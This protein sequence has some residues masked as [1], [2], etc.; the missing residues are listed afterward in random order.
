MYGGVDHPG[1]WFVGEGLEVGNNFS[2][3]YVMFLNRSNVS[4]ACSIDE[5]PTTMFLI[6]GLEMI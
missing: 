2:Y 3:H 1:S 4:L 6:L 5:T